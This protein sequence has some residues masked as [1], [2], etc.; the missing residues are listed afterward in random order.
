MVI[1]VEV[2]T[3]I[4]IVDDEEQIRRFLTITLR[5]AG[6][7]PIQAIN[8]QAAVEQCLEHPPT[9]MLLDLG[10]PDIDG[11]E[12]I[13]R[14]RTRTMLPIIVL[15]VRNEDADKVKALDEGA[16]DYVEKPFRT[17]ELLARIRACLR[18]NINVNEA[19]I[20]LGELRINVAAHEV[21]VAGQV[22]HLSKKEFDLLLVLARTA[23][24]VCTHRQLL[25]SVW[26]PA[27]REDMHYLR[28]YIG[29]LRNKLGEQFKQS[30]SIDNEQGIGYRLKL[31]H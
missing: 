2:P 18:S 23:G 12:V 8:G 27:H 1:E 5:T 4:L 9:L 21:S 13:R 17:A 22:I 26:G 25:E 14:V 10:L 6:Y 7:E 30:L 31:N 28:I 3:K 19:I 20:E 16:N 15:S 29:Q 24:R 11:H